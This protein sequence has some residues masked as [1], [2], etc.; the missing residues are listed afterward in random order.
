[1]SIP[2]YDLAIIGGGINGAGIAREAA[3]QGLSVFLCEKGDLASATSSASSKLVHGGLRYLEYGEFRLVREA[4]AERETLLSIAP[5]IVWPL[6]FILPHSRDTRPAWMIR[7]GLFLYDHLSARK[8]IAPSASVDFAKQC[9]YR[10]MLNPAYKKGF[11]YTDCWVDDA[12]LVVLN[13]V[14]AA[15]HGATIAT[16]TACVKA[17]REDGHWRLDLQGEKNY[18]IHA[19]ALINA[20]G[21]WLNEVIAC[22]GIKT[23]HRVKRVKGSHIVVPK[24]HEGEQAYILQMSDKRIVFVLP[25]ERDFSLI[26]TTDMEYTGDPGKVAI[27]PEEIRYLLGGVNRYVAVPVTEES[28]VWSYAGVRSLYDDASDNLSAMTRDYVL[29]LDT[30]GAPILT[31]FGG[32]ITTYRRLAEQAIEKLAQPMEIVHKPWTHTQPLPGG[33]KLKAELERE[34]AQTYPWLEESLKARWLRQYGTEIYTLLGDASKIS[35]LG[36]EI[37]PQ[38]YEREL[39]YVKEQEWAM[40]GDDFLWRRTKLGLH[41]DANATASVHTWFGK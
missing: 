34:L 16:R 5:H 28:I 9:N 2:Q 14:D 24:L 11:R 4:L 23:P 41:L 6:E 32:K 8:K 20:A 13:A 40:T 19:K 7:F 30:D 18:S 31:V 15:R 36:Q 25:F 3:G 29:E 26:G 33:E 22:T 27:S 38:V 37:A 35:D 12:R 21:P 17:E 39:N 1:M 10:G